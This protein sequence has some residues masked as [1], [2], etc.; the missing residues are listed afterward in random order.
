MNPQAYFIMSRRNSSKFILSISTFNLPFYLNNFNQPPVRGGNGQDQ[1]NPARP[2]YPG[3]RLVTLTSRARAWLVLKGQAQLG[4]AHELVKFF[5][6]L[7]WEFFSELT[8]CSTRLE[9]KA[10]R[11]VLGLVRPQAVF[12]RADK[13]LGSISTPTPLM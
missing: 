9:S 8:S 12:L 7:L 4:L 2:I 13:L 11:L 5:L 10:V 6:N 1:A 3:A